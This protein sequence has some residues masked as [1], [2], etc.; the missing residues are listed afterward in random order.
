MQ[1]EW[2]SPD[3]HYFQ[4]ALLLQILAYLRISLGSPGK[5]EAPAPPFSKGSKA[6]DTSSFWKNIQGSKE[7]HSAPHLN[8]WLTAEPLVEDCR[9]E[10]DLP[11]D[12]FP[13]GVFPADVFPQTRQW[14]RRS[15]VKMCCWSLLTSTVL[16][17]PHFILVSSCFFIWKLPSSM[18]LKGLKIQVS[19]A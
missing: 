9:A 15:T 11:A 16:S 10:W 13:T 12:V 4:R 6:G 7:P 2:I 19:D 1:T 17:N 18:A 8:H 14:S 3:R 5:Q